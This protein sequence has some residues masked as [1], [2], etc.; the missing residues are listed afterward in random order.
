MKS[1]DSI[2]EAGDAKEVK[3]ASK[4]KKRR[5]LS[6]GEKLKETINRLRS[7][8]DR[9]QAGSQ[10]KSGNIHGV[11]AALEKL[12]LMDVYAD[13]ANLDTNFERLRL[14]ID[15]TEQIAKM[16]LGTDAWG[17]DKTDSTGSVK[18]W[19]S[20]RAEELQDFWR[21]VLDETDGAEVHDDL[22]SE[23]RAEKFQSCLADYADLSFVAEE[24]SAEGLRED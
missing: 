18:E 11:I 12:E 24:L 2:P 6:P 22:K 9:I 19:C 17:K 3:E 7:D 21:E 15:V 23:V 8:F 16:I 5:K 14:A 1:G 10:W 13:V 4:D 20:E